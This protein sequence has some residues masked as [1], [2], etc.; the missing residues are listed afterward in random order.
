MTA[1]MAATETSDLVRQLAAFRA[2]NGCALSVYVGFDPSS[3]PTTPEVEAKFSAVL[4]GAEKEAET[5]AQGRGHDCRGAVRADLEQIRSWWDGEFDR[6]GAHG[7]AIFV[8]SADGLFRT[9]PLPADSGDSVRI[10]SSLHLGPIAGRLGRDDGVLVAVVSRERG[11]V[12]RLARGRLHE[13]VDESDEVPGQHTQ[14]GW[15]QARYR[16][17]IEQL[18]KQHL[19]TIG[20][21]VDKRVHMERHLR[22]IVVCSEDLR[23]E[24]EAALSNE[25]RASL[26]GWTNADAHAAPDELLDLVQPLLDEAAAHD[27]RELLERWQEEHGRGGRSAAGWKQVLDAASDARVETLLLG[28]SPR[29][30]AWQCPQC[31]RASADGG[32]C[33]LDNARLEEHPD[34]ADL[35]IQQ[36][37][38]H[39]GALVRLGAGALGDA[40]GVAAL[41][42]F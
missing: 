7:V 22:M 9:V 8:S 37:V 41:L 39:G 26:A 28:E 4:S 25:A 15:A 30:Q 23:G 38:L 29:R 34:A 12:Y 24:F 36:T 32:K 5:R 2:S 40:A 35:A 18:V 31:G 14:G 3:T 42:R 27:E 1:P 13:V 17:H 19:K 20:G 16:R 33:P 6:G 11:T 21:E 10:G